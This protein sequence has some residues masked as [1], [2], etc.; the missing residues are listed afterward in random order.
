MMGFFQIV[1][2][3]KLVNG[4]QVSRESFGIKVLKKNWLTQRGYTSVQL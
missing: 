3:I 1:F 4:K 2:K